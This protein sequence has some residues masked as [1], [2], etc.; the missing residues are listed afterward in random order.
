MKILYRIKEISH[1]CSLPYIV[2]LTVEDIQ[3]QNPK[4]AENEIKTQTCIWLLNKNTGSSKIMEMHIHNFKGNWV[5]REDSLSS[6]DL[7]KY[8]F[9]H[10]RAELSCIVL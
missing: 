9:I 8:V 3:R 4:F 1:E 10:K 7:N 6:K 2:Q 5:L